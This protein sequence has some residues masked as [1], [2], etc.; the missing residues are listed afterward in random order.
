M[1]TRFD[2]KTVIVTGAAG[3]LGA[4]VA[5]RLAFEGVSNLVLADMNA[6]ALGPISEEIGATGVNVL[7]ENLDVTD[8]D[9][10]DAL[11]SRTVDR[12]GALDALVNSAGI[13]SPNARI[14]NLSTADW[15]RSFAVNSTGTFHGVRAVARTMRKRGAVSIVNVAS[16][17]GITAWAYAAPYCASKAAVIHL[18]RVAA[19]EYAKEGIRVNAVCP[20]TFPSA[21]HEGL[22]PEALASIEAK[23]PLGFGAPDDIAGAIAYLA[24]D[25]SR[26]VTGHSLVVDGGYSL[27]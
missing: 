23:H 17:S 11:V 7:A 20:G 3:A 22:P 10:F 6:A 9:G 16:V 13:V 4:T 26:W 15:E 12:F 27:P 25:D 8:G 2:S 18:T 1:S 24:S 21:L 19:L 14:H 5:R